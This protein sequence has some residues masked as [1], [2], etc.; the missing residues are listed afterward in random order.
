MGGTECRRSAA[1]RPPDDSYPR[2]AATGGVTA[3]P[4][5]LHIQVFHLVVDIARR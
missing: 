2:V 5:R 3:D 1:A 4:E